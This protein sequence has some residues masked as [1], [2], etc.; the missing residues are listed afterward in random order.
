M[1]VSPLLQEAM[2][3][4]KLPLTIAGLQDAKLRLALVTQ[5]EQIREISAEVT[6]LIQQIYDNALAEQKSRDAA[7]L[8]QLKQHYKNEEDKR[9]NEAYKTA[10]A[11][12]TE[13]IE[14]YKKTENPNM[15]DF[16]LMSLQSKL[17]IHSMALFLDK[18]LENQYKQAV[19]EMLKAKKLQFTI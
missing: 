14:N 1:T 3:V 18:N 7:E 15:G 9:N 8:E 17:K 12:A 5:T 13:E 6:D 19:N 11:K 2:K 4:M 10:L 16:Y